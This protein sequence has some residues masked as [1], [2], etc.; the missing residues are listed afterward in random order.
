M[1][2]YTTTKLIFGT[3]NSKFIPKGFLGWHIC[4]Y[5]LITKNKFGIIWFPRP[6]KSLFWTGYPNCSNYIQWLKKILFW[7]RAI[8]HPKKFFV[9]PWIT[10]RKLHPMATNENN[11]SPLC[12]FLSQKIVWTSLNY[13]SSY[14][15][16]G[17]N[18]K[19]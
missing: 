2:S 9:C 10:V 17:S 6:L 11:F 5:I 13:S 7:H 19:W 8:I 3:E 18:S 12:H 14:T 1:Q 16:P 4:P 15:Y